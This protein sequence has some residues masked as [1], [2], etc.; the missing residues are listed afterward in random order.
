M[1]SFNL[2]QSLSCCCVVI[3]WKLL[4]AIIS[5]IT[6]YLDASSVAVVLW[7]R[8]TLLISKFHL[9]FYSKLYFVEPLYCIRNMAVTIVIP[10]TVVTLLRDFMNRLMC[11]YTSYVIISISFFI[12]N[13]HFW[14]VL[15]GCWQGHP[16][17]CVFYP[18]GVWVLFPTNILIIS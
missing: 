12:G 2:S 5:V 8:K 10:A 13:S 15:T 9:P 11:N 4:H 17:S 18:Q 16:L 6:L 7:L 1:L 3:V 14:T